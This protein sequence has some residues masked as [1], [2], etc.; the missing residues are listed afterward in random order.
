M[1]FLT[2]FTNFLSVMF[3]FLEKFP[4]K[5]M[6]IQLKD[7]VTLVSRT[8]RHL[9]RYDD[10][11]LR[12][13]VGCI[14]YRYREAKQSSPLTD[15]ILNEELLEVL[16]IS[17]QNGQG[18]LFPKG[19]WETTDES[20]EK[21]AMRETR[22]EAGVTGDIERKLGRWEY[23]S[24]RRS[25]VHE[26]YMFP[27][28]V[29]AELESWPEKNIRERRWVSVTEAREICPQWWMREALEEFVRRQTNLKCRGS[30]E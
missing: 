9:Q 28:R 13:V 15:G 18:M 29:K 6:P 11:G 4:V 14:P 26:G 17:A 1:R 3:A 2:N 22:E 7:M 20:M 25:I 23:K 8:G 24:K 19:G 27:L 12:Q 30:E 21:A 10:K 16:V 5:I